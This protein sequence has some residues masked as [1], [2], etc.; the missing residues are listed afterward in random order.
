[1]TKTKISKRAYFSYLFLLLPVF[2]INCGKTEDEGLI[3][4][5]LSC[6]EINWIIHKSENFSLYAPEGSY[7]AE[8]L[9]EL[10]K[11]T[12]TAR[13]L[14]MERLQVVKQEKPPRLIFLEN[15]D[16]VSGL[17]GMASGGR[18]VVEENGIFYL[19]NEDID[20]PLQHELGHLY[21]W[22]SWGDPAASWL[23]E[24]VAVYT[25]GD[26][27]GE[28]LHAWAAKMALENKLL[29]FTELELD[30]D[31]SKAEPH[32]QAGSFIKY[33][34]EKYGVLSFRILWENGL[35]A[36]LDATQLEMDSL[37]VDW[38]NHIMQKEFTAAA[39]HLVLEEKIRC[40]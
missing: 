10:A 36:S 22:R 4:S 15:S 23:S 3:S 19:K 24:G 26:C 8:R 34:M 12:E 18:A 9:P 27:A 14:V 32:L 33:I 31:F 35:S 1:M 28:D 16:Q 2:F 21:S 20:P 29:D 13:Q 6:N 25:G 30:F 37:L 38:T 5:T 11:K 40:E 39:Q 17:F 7:A